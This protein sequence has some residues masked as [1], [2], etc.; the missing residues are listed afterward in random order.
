MVGVGLLGAKFT[1]SIVRL[2]PPL[3]TAF[4][5]FIWLRI[6]PVNVNAL[7][8]TPDAIPNEMETA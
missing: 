2:L 3:N 1:P 8:T 5:G 4:G 6:G 7:F